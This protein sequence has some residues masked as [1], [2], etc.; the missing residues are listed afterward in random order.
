MKTKQATR[1]A[2]KSSHDKPA[3]DRVDR[4]SAESFPASDPPSWTPLVARPPA[5]RTTNPKK[6]ERFRC[7]TCGMEIQVTV[8]CNCQ[9]PDH[10]HFQCCGQ[11]LQTV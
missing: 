1:P 4:N 9:D 7:E 11:E 10:V 2:A 6:G 5:P 8:D 3:L